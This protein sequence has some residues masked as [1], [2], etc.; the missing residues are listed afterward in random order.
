MVHSSGHT[1]Q[2]KFDVFS[3]LVVYPLSVGVFLLM[4]MRGLTLRSSILFIVFLFSYFIGNMVVKK[5]GGKDFPWIWRLGIPLIFLGLV[6][7]L[8][9]FYFADGIPLFNLSMRKKMFAPLTYLSFLI[10]PGCIITVGKCFLEKRPKEAIGW[11]LIGLFLISLVGYRTE[12]LALV[13]STTLVIYYINQSLQRL[14]EKNIGLI[15]GIVF[16]S[17]L[18]VNVKNV[19]LS[20]LSRSWM[21]LS[22]FSSLVSEFGFSFFGYGHG[23]LTQS[24][25][26]SLGIISGP[27]WGPRGLVSR[28]IDMGDVTTTST[29]LGMPYVD[30][31]LIGILVLGFLLGVLFSKGYKCLKA[32]NKDILP[33]HALC[34]SFL[35]LTIE[36]GIGDI[37]VIGYF[38]A[39]AL[40]VF[41]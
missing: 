31:G 27:S 2:I 23:I 20:L 10:V 8:I 18:I 28:M 26:S 33:I 41:L 22:V 34:L 11:F 29:I 4:G 3:P 16:L 37:I 6:A 32:G 13:L 7:E 40:I 36:T 39:Y 21:T 12:I 35:I 15:L 5:R 38:L 30:F 19:Q 14:V 1:E 24:I 25:F 17:L 9:N